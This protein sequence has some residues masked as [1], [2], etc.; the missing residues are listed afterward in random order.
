MLLLLTLATTVQ[1]QFNYYTTSDGDVT[2]T[3]YDCS[4]GAVTIPD[5]IEGLPVTSIGSSAFYRCTSLTSVTIP[6]SVTTIGGGAFWGCTSLTSVTIGNSVTSIEQSA[7]RGNSRVDGSRTRTRAARPS[8]TPIVAD[9]GCAGRCSRGRC[10]GP[11]ASRT[12]AKRC[13]RV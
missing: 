10:G 13:R 6:D 3:G 11:H 9:S 5:T 1:A 12:G 8:L 7:F 2:I 4:G